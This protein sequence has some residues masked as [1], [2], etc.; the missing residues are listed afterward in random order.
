MLYKLQQMETVLQMLAIK[1][2]NVRDLMPDAAA[3]TKI[4]VFIFFF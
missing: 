4:K 1:H 3:W 2:K